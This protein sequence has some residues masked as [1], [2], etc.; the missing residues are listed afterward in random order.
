M[1]PDVKKYLEHIMDAINEIE[2]FVSGVKNYSEFNKNKMLVRA[3]ERNLEIIGEAFN[4]IRKEDAAFTISNMKAIISMRNRVIH[5][6]DSIDNSVIWAI[7]LKHLPKLK[8]EV[9]ELLK[10]N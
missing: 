6:Y 5:A 7:I 4:R 1:L 9:E 2:N 10:V 3:V 8:S